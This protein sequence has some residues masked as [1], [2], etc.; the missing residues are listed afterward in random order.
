MT[1][2]GT[3]PGGP[4]NGGARNGP[5][6]IGNSPE[7]RADYTKEQMRYAPHIVFL[8]ALERLDEAMAGLEDPYP[9][10]LAWSSGLDE[11]AFAQRQFWE[12]A[13]RIEAIEDELY[14]DYGGISV[15][16]YVALWKPVYVGVMR[17]AGMFQQ[18]TQGNERKGRDLQNDLG[19]RSMTEAES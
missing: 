5:P 7:F 3:G 15:L 13:D 4:G 9:A 1:T 11:W 8:K 14:A 6:E 10:Y 19:V 18:M 16:E 12:H 2:G 17:R